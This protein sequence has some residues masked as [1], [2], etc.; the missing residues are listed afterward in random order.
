MKK[1]FSKILIANRG[2][3]ALRIIRAAQKLSVKTIAIY[4]RGEE[5]SRHVTEADEAVC[6]GEGDLNATYLNIEK[7]LFIAQVKGADAI[8]PGYGFLSE[9]AEFARQCE[10][11]GFVFIGP[12]AD[13]LEKM[14]NKITAK[15]I[16]QSVGVN[17]LSSVKI[18]KAESIPSAL[19][20]PLLIKAS[21][22]GGGKGMQ[23]VRSE[24]ELIEKLESASRSALNYFGNGEVYCEDYIENARHIEVQLLGDHFGNLVHLYERDCTIQRN[25]QKIIEEAPATCISDELR[26]ELHLAALKIGRAVNYQNAGTVEFLVDEN[27]QYYFLEM[28]PRIQV[29]HPVTEE[30]T[31]VDIV[32]EQLNIAAG[33]HLPFTQNDV[34]I[35]GHA[36]EARIYQ[37]DPA[38]DFVP[39]T[40]PISF[41]QFP[42]EID[43]RIESDLKVN[44]GAVPQYDPLL[45][46]FIVEAPTREQAILQLSCSLTGVYVDGPKCNANYLNAILNH[47]DFFTNTTTTNF[48]KNEHRLLVEHSEMS[49]NQ[50]DLGVL[51]SATILFN[52]NKME[53][54]SIW[55]SIG[56]WRMDDRLELE[57]D[58]KIYQ[59]R[60]NKRNDDYEIWL[61]DFC[62]PVRIKGHSKDTLILRI[63]KSIEFV[64][65]I[66]LQN[67]KTRIG[68]NGFIY[69]VKWMDLLEHYPEVDI[70]QNNQ[71][72]ESTN[73]ITSH[74]HGKIVSVNVK[75]DQN[76]N[77][78]E[79]LLVIE[80]MKSENAIKA[81]KDAKI[82]NI[83]VA[84]GSQVTDRMPLV[85]LKD[86]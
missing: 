18:S 69:D 70:N 53:S 11:K 79:V 74:L 78:G 31:G 28:N 9:N 42:D 59:I 64:T 62:M 45:A 34:R 65:L 67:S 60:W 46:K 10:T 39:S 56:F 55:N 80:S 7:I 50:V 85:Y 73:V 83:T 54:R 1:K 36:I 24:S 16:A 2:E 3:I 14:G 23:V 72:H 68:Y 57:F 84:V 81:P 40:Q 58:N 30:I 15:E 77:Q 32:A 76:V 27:E 33:N 66:S 26:S 37:E 35:M 6:L 43:L 5:K 13:V 44:S 86:E 25:H 41:F 47:P 51:F 12:N 4:A 29:E 19:K 38:C 52:Q 17:V 63:G 49:K 8:H 22:G 75:K 82:E 61:N 48:C 71:T 20:F 21:Y